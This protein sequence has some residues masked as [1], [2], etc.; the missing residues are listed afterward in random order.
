MAKFYLIALVFRF[1]T[2]LLL[3]ADR[4]RILV[5]AAEISS[6]HGDQPIYLRISSQDQ[7]ATV[8]VTQPAIAMEIAVISPRCNTV[9]L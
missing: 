2:F 6:G 3:C 4:Y 1:D 7:A 9:K 5:C 8:H